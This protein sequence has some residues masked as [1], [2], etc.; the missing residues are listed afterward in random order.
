MKIS[1]FG[2]NQNKDLIVEVS[3]GRILSLMTGM[4]VGMDRVVQST[5]V[6]GIAM[7]MTIARINAN[8][9]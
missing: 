3:N 6:D 2:F 7:T 1:V 4:I 8:S 9:L 5:I